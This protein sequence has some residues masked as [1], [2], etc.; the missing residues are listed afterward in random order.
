[1]S[2]HVDIYNIPVVLICLA[3]S[4]GYIVP[5]PIMY[6]PTAGM[7]DLSVDDMQSDSH[8]TSSLGYGIRSVTF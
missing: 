2:R 7:L 4:I 1:M 5:I 8:P 6:I 3:T